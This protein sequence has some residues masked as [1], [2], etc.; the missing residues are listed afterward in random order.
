MTQQLAQTDRLQE[1]EQRRDE[2][3]RYYK[4]GQFKKS[5]ALS[6]ENLQLA[7]SLQD[8]AREGYTLNDIGLAHLCCWQ[9]EE[10]SAFFEQALSIA[11]EIDNRRAEAI[12]SSNL[13]ST[14]SRLG[15]FAQALKY[16][17]DSLPIFRELKDNLSEVSTLNDVAL[18]YTK[19]G[20]PKRA[21][22]LQHQILA[23]RRTL[24]VIRA[25]Q[26]LLTALVSLTVT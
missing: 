7:K 15:Q 1:W 14:Y 20:E 3:N 6:T 11:R 26:L 18:I 16:F 12:A 23:M 8:L 13:G 24:G 10:A 22:I 21:L 17:N 2:A 9:L 5:L 25:R 4:Q 19:L